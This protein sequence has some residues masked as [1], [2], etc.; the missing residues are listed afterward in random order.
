[1]FLS[2][3]LSA[4]VEVPGS[5]N[6]SSMSHSQTPRDQSEHLEPPRPGNQTETRPVSSMQ[7]KKKNKPLMGK[8]TG[9]GLDI[10]L[11]TMYYSFSLY[12]KKISR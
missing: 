1:M 9:S 12:N 2:W 3:C 7:G 8:R 11:Q 4:S 6:E 10:G 5:E